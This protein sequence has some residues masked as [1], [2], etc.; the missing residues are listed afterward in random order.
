[1]TCRARLYVTS[2]SRHS[3]SR[4]QRNRR[5]CC[6]L[7]CTGRNPPTSCSWSLFFC[8]CLGR[9]YFHAHD[10][11]RGMN[12]KDGMPQIPSLQHCKSTS[13]HR[14][15]DQSASPQVAY[16][17][18]SIPTGIQRRPIP[19]PRRSSEVFGLSSCHCRSGGDF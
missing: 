4:C 13:G 2:E 10:T 12:Y 19:I 9:S 8:T 6:F 3:Y 15:A 18:S 7:S 5:S 11:P 1:M 14:Y 16:H 17:Q